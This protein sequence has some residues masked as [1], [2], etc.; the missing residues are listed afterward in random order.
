M[1]G[2]LTVFGWH[3]VEPTYCFPGAGS[4]AAGLERQLRRLR[5]LANVVPL[6]DGLDALRAGRPL[7]PRAVALCWDDGYRDNLDLA[8]PILERLGLPGTFF[9]VPALLSGDGCAWWESVGEAFAR[10]SRDQVTW[11]G[12]TLFTHGPRGRAGYGLVTEALRAMTAHERETAVEEL[13]A[14]LTPGRKSE[15]GRLFMD[16]TAARDLVRRG[17]GVGSHSLRHHNLARERPEDQLADLSIS[18]R[19]LESELEVPVDVVAYPFGQ[20]DAVSP[21]TQQ[22]ASAAGYRHGLTTEAGWNTCHTRE[23]Q[24]HRIMLDPG[25]GFAMAAWTRVRARLPLPSRAA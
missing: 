16:W 1:S 13:L 3:N 5:R 4:G 9:L 8:V 7:P 11:R 2:R 14:I 10:S 22:A 19:Q 20:T 15:T 25:Q 21:D 6:E 24:G 17:F 23:T 18:K 12:T